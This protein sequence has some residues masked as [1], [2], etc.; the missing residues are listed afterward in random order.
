[1]FLKKKLLLIFLKMRLKYK[2]GFTLI[3]LL[4]VIAIIGILASI[5]LTSLTSAKTKATDTA[6]LSNMRGV[7]SELVM[8]ADEAVGFASSASDTPS[9]SYKPV[10]GAV[11][12]VTANNGATAVTG[13]T[14]VWPALPGTWA[15]VEP[16]S[17]PNMSLGANAYTFR[18][19][20]DG[21]ENAGVTAV[22]C[23][24]SS[25]SCVTSTL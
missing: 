12:C 16:A 1:L 19:T 21:T 23:T 22:T 24:L 10:I 3:E 6:A 2:K 14:A 17:A 15:Y 20:S 8:C 5:V 7:M 18:A 11:I 9:V 25:N 13:H 4:V